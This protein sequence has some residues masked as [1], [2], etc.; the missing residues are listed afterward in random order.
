MSRNL[1]QILD[2][3]NFV[4]SKIKQGYTYT[5]EEYNLILPFVVQDVYSKIKE[6][7][8]K[9]QRN[10]DSTR[11]LKVIMG[12]TTA[13]LFINNSGHAIMPDDYFYFDSLNYKMNKENYPITILTG[14]EFTQRKSSSLLRPSHYFPVCT[15]RNNYIEFLPRDLKMVDFI[16]L[17]NPDEPYF[18]YYINTDGESVYM[19]PNTYHTL[20]T[21]EVY[22]DGVTTTGV[23]RSKTVEI[24][25]NDNIQEMI[26]SRLLEKIGIR[27]ES[28]GI[29]QFSQLTKQ[30]ANESKQSNQA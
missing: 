18:D 8:E 11:E 28:Q 13:P 30:E 29:I 19:P 1:G 7:Y 22:S 10:I 25:D 16:Y 24:S 17:K 20:A 15:F 23:V 3:L 26:I 2:Y 14:A 5:N 4:C 6:D 9:D 12:D 27:L 21:G